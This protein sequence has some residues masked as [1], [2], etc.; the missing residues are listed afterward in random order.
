MAGTLTR[1]DIIDGIREVII[2][3]RDA[4]TAATMQ[5]VGGAAIALTVDGDRPAT[6]DIDG[7]I[8]PLEDVEAV[9]T[10]IAT[11]RGWPLNWINDKAKIF[12]PDGM[13]RSPEWVTLYDR[14]RICLQVASPAMLLA[15]KLR[16]VERRGLRDAGD[17]AV[18]LATTGIHSADDAEE[19][20]NSFF[21]GED[22][23]PK[24]YDRV[25]ALLDAGLPP[26]QLPNPPD[27]S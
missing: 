16:A 2:R 23:S 7:P 22:L 6:V 5:I 12:L 26:V 24:T 13:G 20:L 19:L 3:L 10:E 9:A 21:P 18:L 27:F 1:N 15:M 14:D 4:G 8:M 11:E 17:V 25:R